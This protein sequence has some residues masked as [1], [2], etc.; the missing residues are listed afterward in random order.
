MADTGNPMIDL[1]RRLELVSTSARAMVEVI[2]L[3]EVPLSRWK[4]RSR[5]MEH[6]KAVLAMADDMLQEH[7]EI[8]QELHDIGY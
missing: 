3:M 8:R 4:V 1:E 6:A 2:L 7:R 5:A